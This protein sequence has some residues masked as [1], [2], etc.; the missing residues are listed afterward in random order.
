MKHRGSTEK[1]YFQY[2]LIEQKIFIQGLLNQEY[3]LFL[4]NIQSESE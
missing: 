1:N 3:V 2:K 4:L